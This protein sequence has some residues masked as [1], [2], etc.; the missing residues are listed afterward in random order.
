MA[1]FSAARFDGRADGR[2][3]MSREIVSDDDLAGPEGWREAVADVEVEARGCHGSV[4][5]HARADAFE[6]QGCDHRLVLA[7]VARC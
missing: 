6:R 5:P 4:E 3:V 2:A 1:E 7:L